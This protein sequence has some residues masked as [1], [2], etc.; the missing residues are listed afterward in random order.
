VTFAG[1]T[2]IVA[3]TALL[4]VTWLRLQRS[5]SQPVSDVLTAV[6]GLAAATGGLM[7]VGDAGTA[8]W[9]VAPSATVTGLIL[10]RRVLFH[11]DGPF[12]T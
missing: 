6:C 10:H 11:G 5:V 4:L 12:R 1:W 3:A 7:V 9:I 2:L 8:S